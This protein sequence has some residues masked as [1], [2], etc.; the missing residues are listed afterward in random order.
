MIDVY[1]V[2]HI[3]HPGRA[4][5]VELIYD[6]GYEPPWECD[7]GCGVVSEWRYGQPPDDECEWE[8]C[9]DRGSYRVYNWVETLEKAKR[10]G[11]G[12]MSAEAIVT[13]SQKLGRLATDTDLL[14][15]V[16]RKDFERLKSWCDNDW[17]YIGISVTD[18]ESGECDSLWGIESDGESFIDETIGELASGLHPLAERE[19]A[20]NLEMCSD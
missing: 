18:D 6:Q 5:T 8:L 10:E 2:R 12:D 4:M 19:E 14:L 7:N 1:K 16:V 13:C 20:A 17:Y 9:W 15:E 3:T 11:W